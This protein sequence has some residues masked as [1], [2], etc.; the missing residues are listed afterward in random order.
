VLN[1]PRVTDSQEKPVM[2]L[3]G[4]VVVR[5]RRH[6][7]TSAE[8]FSSRRLRITRRAQR[9]RSESGAKRP[10]L[11]QTPAGSPTNTATG[12]I[13][14]LKRLSCHTI[15]ASHP[16]NSRKSHLSTK[17]MLAGLE[18]HT[19]DVALTVWS[20]RTHGG[21]KWMPLA[22]VSWQLAVSRG[23]RLARK[24]RVSP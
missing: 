18:D 22:R 23:H 15:P 20:G 5:H 8:R 16:R 3:E 12:S 11:M 6:A 24:A 19:L 9:Q 14:P 13:H 1:L 7:A 2:L 4:A 10:R 17:E 21:L